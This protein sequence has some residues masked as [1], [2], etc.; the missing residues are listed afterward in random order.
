MAAGEG[1]VTLADSNYYEGLELLH[2]S[3]NESY[4][5]PIVCFDVG[6][7]AAQLERS[8][9]LEQLRVVPVTDIPMIAE[10]RDNLDGGTL[11]KPG[12][13]QWP[14]WI[15]PFLIAASPF[16]RTFWFDTDLAVLRNLDQLFRMLDDGP[17]FTP[18]NF[19]PEATANNPRLY[20]LLPIDTPFDPG[21]PKING[22]VSGWDLLRDRE[23]L[24]AYMYPIR[25]ACRDPRI[26]A[27][28]SWWD[29]GALI[30][31]IQ[32]TGS[33]GR[34]LNTWSWNLCVKHTPAADKHYDWD[35]GFLDKLRRDVVDANVVHWNGAPVPWG[36]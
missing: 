25:Q 17:V 31:A 35:A 14:I 22:G 6:L 28:I 32:R 21:E 33:Q 36:S 26:K 20:E 9:L 11:A 13:R 2:R 3:V 12:K 23:I 34:V 18:E 19:A 7:T 16:R 10:I 4:P 15:C 24:E 5:V 27:A 8:R 29:Q 1:I 30:W